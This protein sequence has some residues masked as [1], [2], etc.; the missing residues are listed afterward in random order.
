MIACAA[1]AALADLA[2]LAAA[3]LEKAPPTDSRFELV[4]DE[5]HDVTLER[6][7]ECGVRQVW[8]ENHDHF[9]VWVLE[10]SRRNKQ[11]AD[12]FDRRN[13]GGRY[14]WSKSPASPM[15]PL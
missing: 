9:S 6:L 3:A 15:G 2:W 11:G 1:G 5:A 8:L 7:V 14:R 4:A 10:A 13:I 12:C